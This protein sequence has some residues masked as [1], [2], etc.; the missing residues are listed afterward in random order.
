MTSLPSVS[1]L[2]M[3]RLDSMEAMVGLLMAG[4]ALIAVAALVGALLLFKFT[5]QGDKHRTLKLVMAGVLL[6]L[7]LGIG[8]CYGILLGGNLVK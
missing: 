2:N 7:C 8:A 6:T 5:P 4:P 3:V 1:M